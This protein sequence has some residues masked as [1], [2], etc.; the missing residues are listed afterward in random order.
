M[1]QRLL[2]S[3]K[4]ARISAYERK[5]PKPPMVVGYSATQFSFLNMYPS[6]ESLIDNDFKITNI[7]PRDATVFKHLDNDTF[8]KITD[9]SKYTKNRELTE[10]EMWVIENESKDWAESEEKRYNETPQ[11]FYATGIC[12]GY[13]T[14]YTSPPVLKFPDKSERYNQYYSNKKQELIRERSLIWK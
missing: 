9:F 8:V 1:L 13:M 4:A 6:F 12:S 2:K 10:P 11:P 5:H 3:W 14:F 7:K